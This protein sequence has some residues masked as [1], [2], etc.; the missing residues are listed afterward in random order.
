MD[1]TL[2]S[3]ST[4]TKQLNIFAGFSVSDGMYSTQELTKQLNIFAGFS[5]S[6]GLY[7]TQELY[8]TVEYIC[9][10]LCV[11]WTVLRRRLNKYAALMGEHTPPGIT[12]FM[13]LVLVIVLEK[14]CHCFCLLILKF[15]QVKRKAFY[16]KKVVCNLDACCVI[17]RPGSEL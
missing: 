5:V 13:T 4:V 6:D 7:S 1:C 9:R 10:I 11:R 8:L 12:F 3:T 17:T 16:V 14:S 2:Y 15:F